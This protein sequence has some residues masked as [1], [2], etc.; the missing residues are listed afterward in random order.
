MQKK[1]ALVMSGGGS[2]GALQVGALKALIEKG[3]QPDILVGTS[4]GAIN[5]SYLAVHGFNLQ[6][7][8]GLI[9]AWS[10]PRVK[11]LLPA[12]YLWLALH[13]L[14]NHPPRISYTRMRD[15]FISYGVTPDLKFATIKNKTLI[16]VA[17]DLNSTSPVLYG[18]DP[19]QSILDGLLA[20][21]AIPPWIAPLHKEDRW[22][23]DGGLVSNLSIESAIKVGATEI[24]ALDLLDMRNLPEEPVSVSQL[25]NRIITTVGQRQVGLELALAAAHGVPVHRL[26]L[27]GDAPV[28]TWDFSH[29]AI[30]I[31]RGYETA[32]QEMDGWEEVWES[33]WTKWF[34]SIKQSVSARLQG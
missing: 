16:L 17:T 34:N 4:V 9:S 33:K 8:E 14:L 23:M 2:R 10:D 3:Y 13:L 11:D 18:V 28:M 21:T 1:L 5:A 29:T 15:F 20:S 27:L 6:S 24:I 30:L 26:N 12:N 19:E 31:E 32:Q 7:L 25:L 22:L